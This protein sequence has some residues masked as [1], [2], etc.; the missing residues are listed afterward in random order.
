MKKR[1]VARA[2]SSPG[3]CLWF[4]HLLLHRPDSEQQRGLY[5][6]FP[7]GHLPRQR[8]SLPVS[9]EM[10]P[11]NTLL[12]LGTTSPSETSSSS[13]SISSS[14]SSNQMILTSELTAKEIGQ[15]VV[16]DAGLLWV[17]SVRL[18]QRIMNFDRVR[19]LA[20]LWFDFVH[21]VCT[22]TPS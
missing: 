20:A 1:R 18:R 16:A 5:P 4:C 11:I 8:A 12:G 10:H 3:S 15:G 13:S 7:A 6:E 22:D 19:T 9:Y 17:V 21:G 2:K 14:S